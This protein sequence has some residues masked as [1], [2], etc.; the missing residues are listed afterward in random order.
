MA[1]TTSCPSSTTEQER[2]LGCPSIILGMKDL[3]RIQ[4]ALKAAA[5]SIS[6]FVPGEVK[7]DQKPLGGGPV[8]AA[9]R[10]ADRALR[11]VLLREGEGWLSEES[12]D[13]LSRLEKQRVWVVDP[14]DG[15]LEFVAGIPEWC[16]SV[17]LVENS[18]VVAGG[19]TNPASGETFLGSLEN[20]LTYNGKAVRA[21][22]RT[23]L[24]GAVVLASRSEVRRGEWEVF[25]NSP[26]AIRPTGSVAYKLALVAA[27][28]ADATWTLVPKHEWD[29]AAGVALVH[30]A[31]GFAECLDRS[32]PTFNNRSPVFPGLI[33]G[34]LALREK[35]RALIEATVPAKATGS[36]S[37]RSRSTISHGPSRGSTTF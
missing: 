14:L 33:A 1:D 13:D 26:I 16:V 19:I 4:E 28:L 7:A 21:S 23:T 37:E 12:T 20:G 9:D 35:I 18:R 15:T 30:A 36:S 29:V 10:A 17:G 5:S 31:G 11:E 24:G 32:M 34:G 8:T 3:D 2:T 22:V 25:G 27:G 6:S